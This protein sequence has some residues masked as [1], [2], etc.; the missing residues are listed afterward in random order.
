[1]SAREPWIKVKVGTRRSPKLAALPSDTARLGYFYTLL[2]AKVQRSM[3]VFGSSFHFEDVMGR[4]GPFLADYV[5]AGLAHIAPDLCPECTARHR[6][7][8]KG[9]VVI[10]D[11]LREQRD[12]TAADR[13]ADLRNGDRNGDVT[14]DV[15]VTVT[16]DVTP[17]QNVSH[18]ER[19]GRLTRAG[20]DRDSDSDSERE[21]LNETVEVNE[22][23]TSGPVEP[24]TNGPRC[25]ECG[26][27]K[28]PVPG[29]SG[30]FVCTHPHRTAAVAS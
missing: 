30:R 3:G 5:K 20:D 16:A 11:F 9:V 25:P 12:P 28:V 27:R 6:A 15:T 14:P 18:A 1:M 7:L 8:P 26:S 17:E 21:K 19:N 2:E 23:R 22:A 10:H 13:Q 4:F 29:Q 24:V